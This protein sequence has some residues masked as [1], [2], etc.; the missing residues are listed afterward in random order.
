MQVE[1]LDT[2]VVDYINELEIKIQEL[3]THNENK[4]HQIHK[5]KNEVIEYQNMNNRYAK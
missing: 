1:G 5:L 2:T 3:E 4:D